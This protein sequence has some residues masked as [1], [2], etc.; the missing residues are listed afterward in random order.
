VIE[1]LDS[2][3]L[4]EEESRDRRK[5][6]KVV[7]EIAMDAVVEGRV[8]LAHPAVADEGGL[9]DNPSRAE[10]STRSGIIDGFYSAPLRQGTA[11]V[12]PFSSAP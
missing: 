4:T 9:R 10:A 11:P 1:L 5:V 3:I 2:E 7:G 12:I 6:G 8:I